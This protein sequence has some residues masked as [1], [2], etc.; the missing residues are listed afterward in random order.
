MEYEAALKA[1][2]AICDDLGQGWHPRVLENLGWHWEAVSPCRRIRISKQHEPKM[3][4]VIMS[5][6]GEFGI[7]WDAWTTSARAGIRRVQAMA[8]AHASEQ[9]AMFSKPVKFATK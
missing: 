9:M 8:Q 3:F 4:W 6:P 7:L 1:A 2:Q 5:A